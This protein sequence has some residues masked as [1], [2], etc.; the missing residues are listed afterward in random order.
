MLHKE[1]P[2][3]WVYKTSDR[4]KAGIPDLLICNNGRLYAAEL[5]I[6]KNKPTR[7]QLYIIKQIER[8]GGRV[9][10]CYSVEEV[11]NMLTK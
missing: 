9:A 3:A 8:A 5:K 2:G 1:F 6:G 11:R 10:M 4:W 7:I